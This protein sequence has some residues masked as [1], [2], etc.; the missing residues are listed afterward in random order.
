MIERQME[1]PMPMPVDL[2]VKKVL[3]SRSAFSAEIPTP[4]SFKHQRH[5]VHVAC[6]CDRSR[7]PVSVKFSLERIFG[8]KPLDAIER[9]FFRGSKQDRRQ[10]VAGAPV[11]SDVS[12][13]QRRECVARELVHERLLPRGLLWYI[14]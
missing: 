11:E 1:S 9:S 12:L 13:S 8:F 7:R 3:N 2:V 10:A 14:D 6:Q 4:Q 5:T